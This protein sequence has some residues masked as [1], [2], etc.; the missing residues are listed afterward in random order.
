MSA[1]PVLTSAAGNGGIV[2]QDG[3]D[4]QLYYGVARIV[5]WLADP[6]F[7][8]VMFEALEDVE[9]RFF[10]PQSDAGHLL[11]R[12]QAKSGSLDR[13]DILAVLDNFVAFDQHYP[14][15]A[16]VFELVTPQLPAKLNWMVRD[17]ER[18]RFA[19]PFYAPFR[20]VLEASDD[21]VRTRLADELGVDRGALL[22]ERGEVVLRPIAGAAG[23]FSLFA[24]AF[25]KTYPHAALKRV[26][27][28]DLVSKARQSPS[29]S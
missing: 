15:T 3:F 16:K 25:E 18:V 27:F 10:A 20:E 8:G 13:A 26:A 22:F 2:A 1:P 12:I 9:A 29:P 7:E 28:D 24:E 5:E 4:Y 21:E 14:R 17:L 11:I 19:G 6:T 23:A